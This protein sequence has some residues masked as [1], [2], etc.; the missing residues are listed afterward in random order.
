MGARLTLQVVTLRQRPDLR[1]AIFAAEFERLWPEYMLRDP[2]ARLYFRTPFFD[3]YLD[4]VLVGLDGDRVVARAFSVP[5]CLGG[6][7]RP[8][9]PDGG[10]DEVIRWAHEDQALGRKPTAVSALEITLLPGLRGAGHSLRM[11]DA[12][13]ASTRALGFADLYAPVRPTGKHHEPFA[14]MADYA[15][16]VRA[17]GLPADAWLRTHVRVGGRI[18]K[19]A[20]YSMTIVGTVAEW[21][22]WTGQSFAQSGPF[23]IDHALT[24]VAIS[25]AHDDGIYLE[26]N[27]WVHHRL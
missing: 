1:P 9:L 20:P 25:L 23:V 4:Y 14:P 7:E 21:S 18:V 26:P 10:W 24:P 8:E 2:A 12:M 6:A 3:R 13:K 17:D 27:V 15:A 11:L 16:R 5:F 19:V 22:R